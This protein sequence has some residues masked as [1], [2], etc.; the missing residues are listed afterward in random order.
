MGQSGL[1]HTKPGE[2]KSIGNRSRSCSH[3]M[4]TFLRFAHTHNMVIS[5][6]SKRIRTG[7]EV[8]VENK[9]LDDPLSPINEHSG[10]ACVV[11]DVSLRTP[12]GRPHKLN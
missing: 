8:V 6:F 7:E 2:K 1:E 5:I 9:Q 3:N 11:F 10:R 12:S 4:A